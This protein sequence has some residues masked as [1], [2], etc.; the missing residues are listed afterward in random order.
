MLTDLGSTN[1]TS[2]N[3]SPVQNW[4]LADGDVVRAGHSSIV[5]RIHG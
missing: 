4:Q 1:G 2:V 5:V 3:G